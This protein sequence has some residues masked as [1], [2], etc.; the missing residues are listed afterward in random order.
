VD[1]L[2]VALLLGGVAW[3][4]HHRR[5][6]SAIYRDLAKHGLVAQAKVLRRRRR[7]PPKGIGIATIEYEFET[8]GGERCTGRAPLGP[9]EYAQSGPG[10]LIPVLYDARTPTLNRPRSY[11]VRKGYMQL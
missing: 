3:L 5:R 4:L 6:Q 8:A 2:V 9:G 11:L 7:R 10:S 1:S